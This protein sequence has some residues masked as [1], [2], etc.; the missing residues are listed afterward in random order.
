[1]CLSPIIS[2]ALTSLWGASWD[3]FLDA[4]ILTLIQVS[5]IVIQVLGLILCFVGI[6]KNEQIPFNIVPNI[7]LILWGCFTIWLALGLYSDLLNWSS[8][9]QVRSLMIWDHLQYVT[10]AFKGSLWILAGAI[11]TATSYIKTNQNP[12]DSIARIVCVGTEFLAFLAGNAYQGR[13]GRSRLAMVFS[14]LTS[15]SARAIQPALETCSMSSSAGILNEVY[16]FGN[17]QAQV[18]RVRI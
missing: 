18:T 3:W 12:R 6:R 1:M 14:C 2:W 11:F 13:L 9:P 4:V 5:V 10:W 7:L 17:Q 15:T 16:A 8:Q